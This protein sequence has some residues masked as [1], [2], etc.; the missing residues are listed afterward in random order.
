MPSQ[1]NS[2]HAPHP[3]RGDNRAPVSGSARCPLAQT[4]SEAREPTS[5]EGTAPIVEPVAAPPAPATE[6]APDLA[7]A[8]PAALADAAT[9]AEATTAADAAVVAEAV[10]AA[11]A[12]DAAE[13][14]EAAEAA[15]AVG[16]AGAPATPQPQ[17]ASPAGSTA[18]AQAA[19]APHAA[20]PE[21]SPSACAE[22][23]A[24][25]FP[26]LFG[27]DGP[28]KPVKLRIHADIQQRAPDVFTRKALSIFMHRHTTG[29][30]YL[31][32]L[33]T[34]PHRYDL[35][36]QPAGDVADEHR[37]AAKDELERRRQIFLARR[38]AERGPGPG[39]G[40]PRHSSTW[41]VPG[42]GQITGPFSR[43][44]LAEP[45]T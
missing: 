42:P 3:R 30:A 10:E 29:N 14:A 32:A 27:R 39:R 4:M 11:D 19:P 17:A 24:A 6:V 34:A 5:P 41:A 31:K 9:A 13:A 26:A 38:A 15:D 2:A 16:A 22:R 7:P 18:A 23:L 36:G 37:A 45:T 28:P 25:L 33:L 12:A 21:M 40:R 20:A 8:A 35:D 43:F 1:G 44:R